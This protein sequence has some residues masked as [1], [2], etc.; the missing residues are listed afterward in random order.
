M[1]SETLT[2]FKTHEIPLPGGDKLMLEVRHN[3]KG[4]EQIVQ[5][6]V[7]SKGEKLST[8]CTCRCTS[9]GKT[10]SSSKD[11]PKGCG[12]CDCTTPTSPKVTCA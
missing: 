8:T 2:T 4:C 7:S 9:G 11:C 3:G 6:F 1:N 5:N 12:G 10:Y